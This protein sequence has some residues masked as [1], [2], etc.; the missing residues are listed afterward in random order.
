ME[1]VLETYEK[2]YDPAEPVVCLDEKPVTLHAD[3]RPGLPLRPGRFARRDYEYVRR[4]TA[5]VFCAFEPKAGR[6]F[7]FVTPQ[8]TGYHFAQVLFRLALAYPGARTIHLVLDNLNIHTR[9]SLVDFYGEAVGQ[10]IWSR[11]TLHYT[12]KH[13]SWL[14]QA[15]IQIS[16]FSRQCLGRRR[17][18]TLPELRRLTAAWKRHANRQRL[19]INWTF[20]RRSARKVFRY[21]YKPSKRSQ[22]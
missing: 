3:S 5:N 9:K 19:S 21:K 17:I 2:P 18:A 1:D 6:H 4:G 16:L 13:A 7:L 22:H 11:F 20:N 8:R 15:E 12:P 14:N 10:D